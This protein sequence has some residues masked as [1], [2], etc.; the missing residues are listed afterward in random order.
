MSKTVYSC[1]SVVTPASVGF[2]VVRVPDDEGAVSR[3]CFS[4]A[5]GSRR[6]GAPS[7]GRLGV[8]S[9][10]VASGSSGHGHF[11]DMSAVSWLSALTRGA[12]GFEVALGVR[13]RWP[14]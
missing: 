7:R 8:N 6:P 2:V 12:L 14:R 13:K 3:A 11:G 1:G 4:P 10:G 9:A 5:S